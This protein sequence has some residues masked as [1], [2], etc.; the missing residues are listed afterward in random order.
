MPSSA[1]QPLLA[2]LTYPVGVN[3]TQY[4]V[5]Q[6]CAHHELDWRYLTFEVGPED[7]GDAVRGLR[8]LGF[9]GAHCAG[10]HKQA[11]VPL[12][13]RTTELAS[14]L[15]AA[16][17]VFR[18]DNQLVGDNSDG[19]A[20]LQAIRATED[21]AE[22][23]AVILGAGYMAKAVAL[24]LLG[25]GIR[26]L[27]I[28]NRTETR[29]RELAAAL[30]E[31]SQVPI[32]AVP[33][34]ERYAIPAETDLLINATS[35]G[36]GDEDVAVPLQTDSLHPGLLVIDVTPNTSRTRFLRDAAQRGGP[37]VDGL[38]ILVERIAL[39]LQRW[40]G[41]DANR[42]VLRDAAEEFLGL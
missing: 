25:G 20:V 13:D 17:I 35:L 28:V 24:E 5:E 23:S 18:E 40:T 22:K 11:V 26:A 16:N 12:L 9:H 7:L 33:W 21:P 19:R 10:V 29:A 15:G 39:D 14:A 42:Q 6:A 3:P 32:A 37:T 1:V 2:L 41:T 36:D 31:K 27:T 38:S 8:A 34:V 4:M 30:S